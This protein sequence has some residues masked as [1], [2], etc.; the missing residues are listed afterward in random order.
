MTAKEADEAKRSLCVPAGVPPSPAIHLGGNHD[1][2]GN[3]G[4]PAS[5]C[6]LAAA[7]SFCERRFD[8]DSLRFSRASFFLCATILA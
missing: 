6:D 5:Y 7:E 8:A 2:G 1:L 3:R 4:E